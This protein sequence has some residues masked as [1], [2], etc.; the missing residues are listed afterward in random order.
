MLA[1]ELALA[2]L[3]DVLA[4]ELMLADEL[5]PAMSTSFRPSWPFE[6]LRR[7]YESLT[8]EGLNG[9]AYLVP[10]HSWNFPGTIFFGLRFQRTANNRGGCST[11]LPDP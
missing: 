4:D 6:G 8:Y 2:M 3:A 9:L 1:D 7:P 10:E 11:R 5:A